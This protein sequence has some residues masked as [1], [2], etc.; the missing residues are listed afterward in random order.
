[1]LT[2][3]VLSERQITWSVYEWRLMILQLLQETN[4]ATIFHCHWNLSCPWKVSLSRH[5]RLTHHPGSPSRSAIWIFH[6]LI[7]KS[8]FV[9]G[10]DNGKDL[11]RELLEGIYEGVK[12]EPII[13][14][15]DHLDF[16]ESI[17]K[18]IVGKKVSLI[19]PW[20][21]LM[22]VQFLFVL[23]FFI[24]HKTLTLRTALLRHRFKGF[25]QSMVLIVVIL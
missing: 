10:I 1:M 6:F 16:L 3:V 12:R 5:N 14:G 21:M 7:Y 20:R 2:F 8:H 23:K 11:P 9:S 13:S 4:D 25:D 19:D 15:R 22:M 17:D 18:S 24:L